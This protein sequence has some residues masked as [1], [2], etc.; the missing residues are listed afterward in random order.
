VQDE[1]GRPL[2]SRISVVD[3]RQRFYAPHDAWIHADD[4]IVREQQSVETRYFHG[5]GE[6]RLE[7]PRERL[8]I[9]VSRGPEYEVARLELD[10]GA[11]AAAPVV[12]TLKRLALP[13]ALR[14]SWSGDLH[15]H[16][17]YGGHYRNTPARL[18][19]QA[20]A[21][22][23]DLVYNLVVNKEQRIPDIA[24]FLTGRDPA[25]P[26]DTL[27]LHG[28][29]YHS[30]YWGHLALLNLTRHLLLPDYTAYPFTAVASPYPHNAMV[31]DLAHAQSGLVA[32][33][34]PFATVPDPQQAESLTN[35]LPV[36][37]AL[38]KVDYYEAVGFANHL[39]TAEV[40]YRLLECGI[41]LP[42]GAGTDFMANYASLRGP[43]G[44]NRVYVPAEG[45]LSAERFLAALKQGRGVATNGPLLALRVT[46]A[47]PGDTL[48][49][50]P[51]TH[52]LAYRATLRANF[53]VDHLELVSNGKVV[54]RLEPGAEGRQADVQG[55][56]T[57]SESS[58]ILLRA[59]SDGPRSEVL[60]IYPYATTSPVYV[61]VGDR[62]RRSRAAADYFL[63]WLGRL[64]AATEARTDYRA[65]Q[66]RAAVLLDIARA[67]DF[68][69]ACQRDASEARR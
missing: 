12:V 66:E 42:A 49:L 2:P 44:L 20:R 9:T 56:I 55:S 46:E 41:R 26:E 30:S 38:G 1:A 8:A 11:A 33:V 45:D 3:G 61:D 58:W 57:I 67:K 18:V 25:S 63:S 34:H 27:L 50:E 68:Y 10:A 21:E 59:W 60:D 53:P 7:V 5:R 62:P 52:S 14:A 64:Q 22:D 54:A 47:P 28:Q 65:P 36:D 43:V 51:G 16:M 37:A 19:E 17:N 32:Y 48:R 35:A 6:A 31:A 69:E 15:V 29:E 39:A 40:W 4:L 13:P 24:A 23:V